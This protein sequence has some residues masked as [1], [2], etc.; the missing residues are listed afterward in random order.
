MGEVPEG[1]EGEEHGA[2]TLDDEEVAPLRER[3]RLNL[4]DAEGEEAPKGGRD[5]LSGVEDRKT[6]AEFS[7]AVEAKDCPES[8]VVS[9]MNR[10]RKCRA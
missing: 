4:E 8:L 5:G 1:E 2:N 6:T 7:A 3:A 10:T 9:Q